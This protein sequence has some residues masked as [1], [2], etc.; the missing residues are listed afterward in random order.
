ME[1][2]LD[3]MFEIRFAADEELIE[4]IKWLKSQLFAAEQ[5]YGKALVEKFLIK[6][7]PGAYLAGASLFYN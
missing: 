3:K 6:E 5:T 2:V 4:L 1:V 7:P